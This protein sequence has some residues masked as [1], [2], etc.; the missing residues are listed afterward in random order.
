MSKFPLHFGRN[1][2][3]CASCVPARSGKILTVVI[4]GLLIGFLGLCFIETPPSL[5]LIAESE[6]QNQGI[7]HI[8]EKLN[9]I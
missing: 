2:E 7:K 1:N 8:I 5:R 9:S 6:K 3:H 4:T